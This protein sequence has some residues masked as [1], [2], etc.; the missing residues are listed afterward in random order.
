MKT[1]EELQEV[2]ENIVDK[3]FED[4]NS[5]SR[6]ERIWFNI[7]PLTTDGIFDQFTNNGAENI[8][9]TI[10]DLEYLGFHNVVNLIKKMNSLFPK[11]NP[12]KDIDDRNE[13]INNWTEKQAELM[14]EID[15]EFWDF[16]DELENGLLEYLNKVEIDKKDL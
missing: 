2:W 15:D 6:D 4:Y 14:E 5:L 12:P 9:D 1:R 13:I 3:G 8:F 10:E 16:S 11:N 7:E